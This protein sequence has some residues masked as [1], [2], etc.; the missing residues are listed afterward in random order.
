MG[1]LSLP[2]EVLE[3]TLRTLLPPFRSQSLAETFVITVAVDLLVARLVSR[4]LHRIATP[5]AW[6]RTQLQIAHPSTMRY[7]NYGLEDTDSTA[8]I[9]ATKTS[10]RSLVRCRFFHEH[11][12]LAAHVRILLLTLVWD[13]ENPDLAR[14]ALRAATSAMSN[15]RTVLVWD[16]DLLCFKDIRHLLQKPLLRAIC[17]M[18]V[19]GSAFPAQRDLSAS[20]KMLHIANSMCPAALVAGT[21]LECVSIEMAGPCYRAPKPVLTLREMPWKTLREVA[22]VDCCNLNEMEWFCFLDG[23]KSRPIDRTLVHG[24]GE[25]NTT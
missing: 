24:W 14:D 2:D 6:R 22:L 3:L 12:E 17:L 1:I 10:I 16:S 11:P 23:F 7:G 19:D 18:D 20:L 21:S 4:R 9:A 25:Y 15:L 8:T 5:L 13:A